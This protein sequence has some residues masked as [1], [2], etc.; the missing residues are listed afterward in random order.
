MDFGNLK[1]PGTVVNSR[2]QVQNGRSTGGG[3]GG[4]LSRLIGGRD[5]TPGFNLTMDWGQ[6]VPFVTKNSATPAPGGTN[7]VQTFDQLNLPPTDGL[8]LSGPTAQETAARNQGISNINAAIGRLGTSREA[9]IR[10]L[11]SSLTNALNS[12]QRDYNLAQNQYNEGRHSTA[13]DYISGK[14]QVRSQAGSALS[15]LLRVLGSMGA[16]GGSAATISAPGAVARQATLQQSGLGDTFAGNNRILD[17][18]WGNF[19]NN[20]ENERESAL[21]QRRQGEQSLDSK[22]DTTRA[23]LLQTLASL[24]SSPKAAQPYLDQANSALNRVAG[25]SADPIKFNAQ[26]YTAPELAQY[27]PRE[28]AGI[29]FQGQTQGNDYTSPYLAALLGRRKEQQGV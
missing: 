12:L 6:G 4:S 14:N 13:E 22:I 23:E 28:V 5:L 2:G 18:N 26:A 24:Q 27:Q 7:T 21:A 1:S 15:G 25:I 29:N 11:D 9:G 8:A 16:G 10:T 3:I 17:T 19:K 20:Y